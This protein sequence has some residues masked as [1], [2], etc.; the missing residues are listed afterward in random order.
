VRRLKEGAADHAFL[1]LSSP[2][3]A[4]L[5]TL[6]AARLYDLSGTL[7]SQWQ[8]L[9]ESLRSALQ[10]YCLDT[11]SSG[12]PV[13]TSYEAALPSSEISFEQALRFANQNFRKPT[14]E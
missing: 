7:I 5:L 6:M 9:P 12:E 1:R 3:W 11:G 10:M 13:E 8:S 2:Q 14:T 4:E